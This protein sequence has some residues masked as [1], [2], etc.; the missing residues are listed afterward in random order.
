[1]RSGKSAG[2]WSYFSNSKGAP[3]PSTAA[4]SVESNLDAQMSSLSLAEAELL[5][6]S[7]TPPDMI[8]SAVRTGDV[9]LIH[10]LG[11]DEGTLGSERETLRQLLSDH[12]AETG[13]PLAQALLDTAGYDRFTKIMPRDYKRVL[14][15]I[16]QARESG[17]DEDAAVMA[18]ASAGPAPAAPPALVRTGKEG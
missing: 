17:V 11:R 15:A 1:M 9:V 16:E 4:T 6:R 10:D 13:S 3:S 8:L 5:E 7:A 14:L 2:G 18:A 12:A